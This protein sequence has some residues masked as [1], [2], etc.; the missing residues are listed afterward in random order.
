M[1][2]L[3]D[4]ERNL[5]ST[6]TR[7]VD[8]VATAAVLME[9]FVCMWNSRSPL[10]SL[11]ASRDPSLDASSSLPSQSGTVVAVANKPNQR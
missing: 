3:L 9:A 8:S 11:R 10:W 4:S 2:R 5:G 1:D 6:S 7:A